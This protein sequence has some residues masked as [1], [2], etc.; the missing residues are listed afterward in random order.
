MKE[1]LKAITTSIYFVTC[2]MPMLLVQ[3]IGRSLFFKL[4]RRSKTTSSRTELIAKVQWA[5]PKHQK[6]WPM[7]KTSNQ[8]KQTRSKANRAK[9]ASRKNQKRKLMKG[10]RIL[11]DSNQTPNNLQVAHYLKVNNNRKTSNDAYNPISRT[12]PDDF[13]QPQKSRDR[14]YLYFCIYKFCPKRR[15]INYY[16]FE[17]LIN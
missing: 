14:I 11:T 6:V 4:K 13:T 5:H 3:R 17:Q 2:P 15:V 8:R 12:F 16:R 1:D 7:Q 9:K 10:S